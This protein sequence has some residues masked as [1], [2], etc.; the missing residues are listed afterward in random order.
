MQK[1]HMMKLRRNL[2]AKYSRM[3]KAV[4]HANRRRLAQASLRKQKHKEVTWD[5]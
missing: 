2:V 3:H 1:S 5:G 4:T